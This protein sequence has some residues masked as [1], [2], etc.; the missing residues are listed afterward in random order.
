MSRAA[1]GGQ[2]DTDHNNNQTP[3][4]LCKLPRHLQLFPLPMLVLLHLLLT[5][6]PSVFLS[7]STA[8]PNAVKSVQR[9]QNN[10]LM[11]DTIIMTPTVLKPIS[12][13]LLT[14]Q[15][16]RTLGFVMADG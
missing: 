6:G 9:V 8:M 5:F 1:S 15:I 10:N 7:T 13:I 11:P 3:A 16:N 14:I 4:A 2:I 12:F